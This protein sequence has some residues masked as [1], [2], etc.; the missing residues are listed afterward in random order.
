MTFKLEDM[1]SYDAKVNKAYVLEAGDYGISLRADAHNV[2][3][4]ETITVDDTIVYDEN[5]KRSTDEEVATNKLDFA[6]GSFESLSRKDHFANY[7][8]ATAAPVNFSMPEEIKAVYENNSNYDPEKYNNDEDVMPVTGAK[9]HVMLEDV[10][11][12]DYDDPEWD[13]LMD[14]WP[15]SIRWTKMMAGRFWH[16]LQTIV[17]PIQSNPYRN[18]LNTLK[19]L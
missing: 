5:N 17:P 18:G 14:D 11:G 15:F 12:L 6:A 8:A 3:A 13:L 4:T 9:N 16:R 7:D 19:T 1:A 2:I 10:R